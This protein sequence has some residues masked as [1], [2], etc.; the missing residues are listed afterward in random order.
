MNPGLPRSGERERIYNTHWLFGAEKQWSVEVRR[1][2]KCSRAR[3]PASI[4]YGRDNLSRF[5]LETSREVSSSELVRIQSSSFRS[6][7]RPLSYMVLQ[8]PVGVKV[9]SRYTCTFTR[10]STAIFSSRSYAKE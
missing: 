1:K 2:P 9:G 8:T 10:V 4:R 6:R 3:R 7:S 5:D